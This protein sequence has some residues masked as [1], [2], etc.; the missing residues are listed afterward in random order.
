MM[1]QKKISGKATTSG[2]VTHGYDWVGEASHPCDAD[3]VA[4]NG[5]RTSVKE[6]SRLPP[7]AIAIEHFTTDC[8]QRPLVGF[9]LL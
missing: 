7:I 9:S 8:D 2:D 4:V 1:K 3:H 6:I 5:S